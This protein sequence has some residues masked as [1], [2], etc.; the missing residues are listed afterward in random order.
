MVLDP[1]CTGITLGEKKIDKTSDTQTALTYVVAA[2]TNIHPL[3]NREFTAKLS[4]FFGFF[5]LS[6]K[7]RARPRLSAHHGARALA[8]EGRRAAA[9]P[10]RRGLLAERRRLL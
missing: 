9:E 5:V 1:S 4:Y 10:V 3:L 8:S 2:D 7:T 6:R